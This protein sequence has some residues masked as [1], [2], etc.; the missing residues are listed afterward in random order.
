MKR[1][2]IEDIV[3]TNNRCTKRIE[4]NYHM[5]DFLH[6]HLTNQLITKGENEN[7]KT[8]EL[9]F[10]LYSIGDHIPN[11]LTGSRI[12]A[13]QRI[14]ELIEASKLADEAGLDVFAVGES[15][16]TY[17]TT[18]AHTVILGAIAQATKILKLQVRRR[19]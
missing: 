9:E 14:H 18:Q 1:G 7:G 17:F 19:C 13:E 16:Q 3:Q 8:K 6:H 12:S 10:G 11:P 15:H 4:N 2:G 5:G